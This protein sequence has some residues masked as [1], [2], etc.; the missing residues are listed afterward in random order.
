MKE[1][2]FNRCRRKNSKTAQK[3][4]NFLVLTR[5]ARQEYVDTTDNEIE[6]K[7]TIF[8][9]ARRYETRTVRDTTIENLVVF[10]SL[11]FFDVIIDIVIDIGLIISSKN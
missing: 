9:A 1:S 8:Q 3:C 7:K 11:K 2:D 5:F 4:K 10:F 6:K